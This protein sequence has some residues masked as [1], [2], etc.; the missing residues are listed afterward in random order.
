MISFVLVVGVDT[1]HSKTISRHQIKL[2]LVLFKSLHP[3]SVLPESSNFLKSFGMCREK[4]SNKIIFS[5]TKTSKRKSCLSQ[6]NIR[7]GH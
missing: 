2:S 1:L 5:S 4:H 3:S 6:M 7:V